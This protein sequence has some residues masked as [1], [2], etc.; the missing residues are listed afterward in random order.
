MRSVLLALLLATV[1]LAVAPA[2]DAPLQTAAALDPPRW[3]APGVRWPEPE[4]APPEPSADPS[5]PAPAPAPV[6]P[7]GGGADRAPTAAAAASAPVAEVWAVVIG[8]DQY[9]GATPDLG[10]AVGDAASMVAVLDRFGVDAAHRSVRL[11]RDATAE[12]VLAGA[13]WLV[14]RAGPED[15]AVLFYAGH[16]RLRQGAQ[17]VVGADGNTVRDTELAAILAPLRAKQTW[18]VMAACFGGGFTELLAPG[19]ILTAASPADELAF[20][21]VELG[22][23]YLS[24]YLLYQALLQGAANASVQDAFSWSQAQLSQRFPNRLLVQDDRLGR[25]LD[26]R[27]PAA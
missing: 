7:P 9:D 1:P 14:D 22:A 15:T 17:V 8:I 21:N 26:L 4:S 23:S 10:S 19:R 18:I 2:P 5:A 27:A 12:G 3:A 24:H 25:P 6:T 20:E 13:R 16:V 11:N